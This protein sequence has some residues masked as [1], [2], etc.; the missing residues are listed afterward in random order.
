MKV[1]TKQNNETPYNDFIRILKDKPRGVYA[2]L[3]HRQ[4]HPC[5]ISSF[6]I[7]KFKYDGAIFANSVVGRRLDVSLTMPAFHLHD[8]NFKLTI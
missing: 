6:A 1:I 2:S 8:I 3:S 4:T 5:E 7:L